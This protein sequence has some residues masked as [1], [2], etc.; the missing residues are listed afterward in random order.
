MSHCF[1]A[2]KTALAG[3]HKID[4]DDHQSDGN[5]KEDGTPGDS[6]SISVS[7]KRMIEPPIMN[8]PALSLEMIISK[9]SRP[10][11]E[12]WDKDSLG[13][14]R[15][16]GYRKQLIRACPSG[17]Q[18]SRKSYEEESQDEGVPRQLVTLLQPLAN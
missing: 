17:N 9:A 18:A 10:C 3:F 4:S 2:D 15:Q 11:E 6:G 1:T 14:K 7:P 16:L 5:E 13:T 8:Q 12:A